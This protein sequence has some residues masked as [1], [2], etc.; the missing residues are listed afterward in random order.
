MGNLL[1]LLLITS[2]S[3]LHTPMYFFL[4]HLSFIDAF[5][6]SVI[7]PKLLR[8]LVSEQ[9]TISSLGCFTQIALVLF[10]GGTE[11]CLLSAMAYDRFQAVCHPLLYVVTMNRKVHDSSVWLSHGASAVFAVQCGD[12]DAKPPYLQPEKQR[13]NSSSAEDADQ[14]AKVYECCEFARTLKSH[15]MDGYRGISL[16]NGVC[17]AQQESNYNTRATNYNRGDQSTNYGIFQ[18]NSRYW[19]NDGKSPGAVNACGVP[20]SVLLQDDITQT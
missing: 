1:M 18:I 19:C 2:D 12:P 20:C 5:Y 16:A 8:N 9:K 14:E 17:L 11:A 10:C 6:S 13:C 15:G 7:V 4:G 3:H